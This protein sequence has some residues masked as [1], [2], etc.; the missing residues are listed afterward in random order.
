MDRKIQGGTGN[1]MFIKTFGDS[2]MNKT[3]DFLIVFDKFDY[4]MMDISEKANIGYS[5]LKT[6]LPK[7]IKKKIL[8]KTRISGK[9]SM[10]KLKK[11]EI[12]A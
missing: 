4:S 6:L 10:Y 8:V 2:P 12:L 7:L 9:S 1:S 3:M 11:Q 5:T